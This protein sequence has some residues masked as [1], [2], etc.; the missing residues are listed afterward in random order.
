MAHGVAS[1]ELTG[2]FVSFD[3][4]SGGQA[5]SSGTRDRLSFMVPMAIT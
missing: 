5:S 3:F 1:F 4:G 2:L